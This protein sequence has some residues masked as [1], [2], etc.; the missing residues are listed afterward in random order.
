MGRRK[1][2]KSFEYEVKWVNMTHEENSWVPR[3]KLEE[4][5]FNKIV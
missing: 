5:G 4:W 2:K 3:D 1:L